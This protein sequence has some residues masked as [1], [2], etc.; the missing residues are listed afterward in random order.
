[1]GG[2]GGEGRGWWEGH[3]GSHGGERTPGTQRNSGGERGNRRVIKEGLKT[4][5]EGGGKL[6]SSS[7][8]M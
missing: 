8:W 6:R 1:M 7:L 3:R 2:G 5:T 4:I